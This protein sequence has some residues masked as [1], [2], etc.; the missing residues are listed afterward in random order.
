MLRLGLTFVLFFLNAV[1]LSLFAYIKLHPQ[2]KIENTGLK[3]QNEASQLQSFEI[4]NLLLQQN[5]YFEKNEQN[6]IMKAPFSW[7]ANTFAIDNFIHQITN[8]EP[9]IHFKIDTNNPEDIDQYGLK[10]P[11]IKLRLNTAQRSYNLFIGEK[12]KANSRLYILEPETQT[13]YVCSPQALET[14]F[15]NLNQWCDTHIFVQNLNN[16]QNLAYDSDNLHVFLAKD[17][18][19]WWLKNPVN[20]HAN[21]RHVD[22]LLQQIQELELLR[23]LDKEE[24][25][26]FVQNL[27][28]KKQIKTLNLTE[29]TQT[30]NMKIADLNA[31]EKLY[32][33][34]IDNYEKPFIFQANWI[35]QLENPQET[36][37][38]RDLFK[39][40]PKT[41]QKITLE[42][43]Q[44]KIV[45]QH[46]K[47][48]RWD[49]LKY[50]EDSLQIASKANFH[51]VQKF[52]QQIRNFSVEEFL[53][54]IPVP[55][56]K[57][58]THRLNFK[59]DL[60]GE[61][62]DA[63]LFTDDKDNYLKLQND[64]TVFK[65]TFVSPEFLDYN[66]ESFRNKTI[67]HWNPDEKLHHLTW[68]SPI[69]SLP[70]KS[71]LQKVN[72]W[73]KDSTSP[74]FWVKLEK[75]LRHLEAKQFINLPKLNQL[76]NPLPTL[77]N[78]LSGLPHQLI[79][80]TI[81]S[82]Q[83]IRRYTLNL[84]ERINGTQQF[85]SVYGTYFLL[86]QKWVDLLFRLV[87]LPDWEMQTAVFNL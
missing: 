55:L 83:N 40:S 28:D 29:D 75:T 79:I 87:E 6:W 61:N 57:T 49:V 46:V 63:S 62:I 1:W 3:I 64:S 37:R 33:G 32:V 35:E 31:S 48:K 39:I 51:A 59:I 4:Q 78:Y 21:N 74:E 24:T 45:L 52:L 47:E 44:E 12:I 17:N 77:T 67:W 54:N 38:D 80:Q 60:N 18:Q 56:E 19:Q 86:N 16:I 26:A 65:L 11:A 85:A 69:K 25:E 27:N 8:F 58:K 76:E 84:S 53:E 43:D 2:K 23:F 41:V 22:V 71:L 36:L 70:Q 34:Q 72:T 10:T 42:K 82:Q 30:F 73:V 66:F 68:L 9:Q 7:N 15:L 50:Q 13:V 81:D 5:F 14:A 20:A